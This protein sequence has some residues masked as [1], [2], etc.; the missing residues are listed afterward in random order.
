MHHDG[1][2]RR[3]LR[4]VV[5]DADQQAAAI[6]S[7]LGLPAEQ[8]AKVLEVE[9]ELLILLG[10]VAAPGYLFRF[11]PADERVSMIPSDCLDVIRV[12]R[13]AERLAG[14][15][16]SVAARILEAETADLAERGLADPGVC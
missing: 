11:Y 9:F 8:V 2:F 3:W 12:A 6:A 14:V 15:P 1:V 7:R 4:R 13:D 10:I 5:V 16:V